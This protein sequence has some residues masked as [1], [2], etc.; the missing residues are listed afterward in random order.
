MKEANL[1]AKDLLLFGRSMGSGP[2]THLAAMHKPGA[3]ILMSPYKS[4]KEVVKDKL[5]LLSHLVQ[6]R[7]NN[8][9]LIADVKCPTFFVHG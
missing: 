9:D 5:G 8:Y 1:K 6:E 7:F 3:L 2:A 4:I